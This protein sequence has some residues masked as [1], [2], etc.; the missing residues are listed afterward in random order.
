MTRGFGATEGHTLRSLRRDGAPGADGGEN[1]APHENEGTMADHSQ[2]RLGKA[3][4]RHAPRPLQFAGSRQPPARPEPPTSSDSTAKVT[5]PWGM[6]ENDR[7]GDCTCAAAGHLIMEWSANAGA[8]A[9]VSDDSVIKA[10]A[11]I[12]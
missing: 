2:M 11:A 7:Y 3:A 6:M 8:Q 10:Y 9:A 1:V 12:T 4:P 5:P